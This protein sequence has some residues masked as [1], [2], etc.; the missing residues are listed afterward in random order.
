MSRSRNDLVELITEFPGI[1]P[2]Q[3]RRIVQFLLAA[4]TP[5]RE[6]LARLIIESGASTS[7]CTI[8]FRFDDSRDSGVC[9]ICA[10]PLRDQATLMVV[11][12]D[13]DIEGIENSGA[14]KGRYF[15]L[16]GLKTM[17]ERK[18][19][20]MVRVSELLTHIA[21]SDVQEVIFALSTTPEGDYTARELAKEIQKAK[22]G[23][24]VTLLGRGLSVGAEIEY[25]D[26]ET[27]RSALKNR[28]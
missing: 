13:I 9:S 12:K 1:G 21:K 25:A 7:P 28:N 5:F 26:A 17:T 3:A 18:N 23:V 4:G 8:C 20:R 14:Y 10:D 2:R 27:L 24:S 19:A 6:K 16:G 15:V 11:E 22:S